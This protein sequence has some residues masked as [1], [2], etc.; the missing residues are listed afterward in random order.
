MLA[1]DENLFICDMAETYHVLDYKAL[2]VETLAVL[3][4][5]LRDS[6]RIKMKMAGLTYIPPE[7][8]FP[9]IADYLMIIARNLSGSKKRDM[10]LLTDL[11]Q[12]GV[13][14]NQQAVGFAS[15]DDFR[16]E[17]ERRTKGDNYG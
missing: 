6:S 14:K 10:K 4:S 17:W 15:G 8:I 1:I 11:M 2:P 16:A 3:A 7:M 5:G 12:K 13:E 9:Q